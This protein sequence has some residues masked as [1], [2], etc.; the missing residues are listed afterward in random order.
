MEWLPV[1]QNE[2]CSSLDHML[3]MEQRFWNVHPLQLGETLESRNQLLLPNIVLEIIL[4]V[5]LK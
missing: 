4:Y 1:H 3:G 5:H 2:G